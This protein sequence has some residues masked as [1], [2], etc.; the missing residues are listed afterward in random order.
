MIKS[1]RQI[2]ENTEYSTKSVF[3]CE[4]TN[5][6]LCAS[7]VSSS[8]S[9]SFVSNI[10]KTNMIYGINTFL[11]DSTLIAKY[12]SK[13]NV[14]SIV[15]NSYFTDPENSGFKFGFY[16]NYSKLNGSLT[17]FIF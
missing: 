17:I 9:L 8:L 3:I 13:Y 10:N 4:D 6:L 11:T 2:I 12:N 5:N 7:L 1:L 15:D 16:V 14:D